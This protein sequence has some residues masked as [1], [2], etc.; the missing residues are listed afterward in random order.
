MKSFTSALFALGLFAAVASEAAA[1]GDGLNVQYYN[2]TGANDRPPGSPLTPIS[3]TA[4]SAYVGVVTTV[5]R[6]SNDAA[7]QTGVNADLFMSVFTGYIMSAEQGQYVFGKDTD[8]GGALFIRPVGSTTWTTVINDWTG[9]GMGT[10][11][12]G[13]YTMAANTYYQI[14]F[15]HYDSGGPGGYLLVWD[16]PGAVGQV[17]IPQSNLYTNVTI[18]APPALGAVG[19]INMVTLD[20]PDVAGATAGYQIYMGTAA[21]NINMT[22]PVYTGTVSGATITGLAPLT[23][24]YFVGVSLATGG[25]ASAPSNPP[26][27]ATTQAP[28]PRTAGHQE[29]LIDDNCACGSSVPGPLLPGLAGIAGLAVLAA[30]RRRK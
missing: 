2:Y 1:Q 16:P 19:G 27:S 24:Y 18:P 4:V 12:T 26:V 17:T 28:P 7:V 23:T 20:W 21:N 8:D 3:T 15:E 22:T 25:L 9:Q 29:G 10:V 13:N 5:D 6:P 11:E 30:T 14:R